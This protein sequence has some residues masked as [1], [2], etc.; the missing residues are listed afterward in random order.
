MS[1][2]AAAGWPLA[3]TLDELSARRIAE[4]LHDITGSRGV[5]VTDG[6]TLLGSA[7]EIC[8]RHEPCLGL[9]DPAVRGA[10]RARRP[11]QA[12]IGTG[13]L[14]EDRG[15]RC[16]PGTVALIPLLLH[17]EVAG[18]VKLYTPA[19]CPS[20]RDLARLMAGISKLIELQ[21]AV[22]EAA[23]HKE[24]VAKARLEALQAQIRPHFLFNTLNTILLYSYTDMRRARELLVRLGDFFRRSLGSR[25]NFIPLVDEIEYLN[26]YLYF[27]KARFG[28][29]LRLSIR[30]DPAALWVEIPVLTLQPLVE[31]AIVH[32][33]APREEGG[34][35][36]IRVRRRGREV[37]AVVADSGVG[38]GPEERRRVL[39]ADFGTGSG[40]G[41]NNVNDRLRAVYGP[42]YG[43][44]I[45]SRRG[46][47]TIV[48][49]RFPV[50][51]PGGRGG[52]RGG[53]PG[54]DRR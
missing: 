31:N 36:H 24:L 4:I 42:A 22:A 54:A 33:L 27:E 35:L 47:G 2:R 43:L 19:T 25:G 21:R 28:E 48:R 12:P 37:H 49:V 41:L 20:G 50:P 45:R 51:D 13:E 40:I 52:A 39:E 10:L 15:C 1:E 9:R 30:V 7:G 46:R 14:C 18:V 26:T 8:T 32:G 17:G 34:M 11:C 53:A 23:V 38:M 6:R 3:W 29:R 16:D 44:R 5:V